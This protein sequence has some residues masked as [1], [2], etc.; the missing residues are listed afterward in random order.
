[1]RSL[2]AAC[3]LGLIA[4]AA[5]SASDLIPEI[6]LH[7]GRFEPAQ[8]T[9][10]AESPFKMRVI[11]AGKSAIE[12]ES[13]ELHRERVVQPGEAI[14]VYMPALNAGTYKFFDDFH[15]STAQGSIVAK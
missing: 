11:N 12:F 6:K 5:A 9:V 2:A 10:K 4:T 7:N 14:T 1:M 8:V 13:F 3:A 15:R